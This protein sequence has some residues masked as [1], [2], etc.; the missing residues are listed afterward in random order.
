MVCGVVLS[1][2]TGELRTRRQ[3]K[4]GVHHHRFHTGRG[5][6]DRARA[7]LRNTR[8]YPDSTGYAVQGLRCRSWICRAIRLRRH[9]GPLAIRLQLPAECAKLPTR[10]VDA[11]HDA[12]ADRYQHAAASLPVCRSLSSLRRLNSIRHPA[13]HNAHTI[14]S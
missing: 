4:P 9:H 7:F 13:D 6:S 2:A 1:G 3:I 12:Y 11:D 10:N 14:S 8:D 5:S